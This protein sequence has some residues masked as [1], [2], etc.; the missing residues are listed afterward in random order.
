MRKILGLTLSVLGM[1]LLSASFA[2]ATPTSSRPTAGSGSWTSS[3]TDSNGTPG[4]QIGNPDGD[5]IPPMN[6]SSG[7]P[8]TFRSFDTPGTQGETPLAPV[9]EPESLILLASGLM[10]LRAFV[11]RKQ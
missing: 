4:T 3:S 7:R 6:F 5:P 10:G 2:S 8:T 9:P 11:R 1:F